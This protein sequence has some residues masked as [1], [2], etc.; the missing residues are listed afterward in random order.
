MFFKWNLLLLKSLPNTKTIEIGIFTLSKII[1]TCMEKHLYNLSFSYLNFFGLIT[2]FFIVSN[3]K[4]NRFPGTGLSHPS[5]T[6]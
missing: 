3:W 4:Q 5:Q 2:N 1:I 6:Q